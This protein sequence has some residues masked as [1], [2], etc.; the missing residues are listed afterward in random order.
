MGRDASEE[1]GRGRSL[2]ERA[3]HRS[4]SESPIRE[5]QTR[6]QHTQDKRSAL[7]K[8][9]GIRHDEE[10]A[11]KFQ[12]VG[13]PA[14]RTLDKTDQSLVSS[15]THQPD[16]AAEGI[17]GPAGDKSINHG[18]MTRENDSNSLGRGSKDDYK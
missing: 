13:S 6:V 18:A 8:Q 14:R 11:A 7:S 15:D 16:A 4:R 17:Q 5:T 9:F 12:R 1:G 3:K 2:G 10:R